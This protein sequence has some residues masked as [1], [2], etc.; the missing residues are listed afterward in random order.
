MLRDRVTSVKEKKRAAPRDAPVNYWSTPIEQLVS[1]LGSTHDG[2]TRSQAARRLQ[3]FGPNALDFS[4]P[5]SI[6]RLIIRQFT[7]PL[8]LIL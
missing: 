3:E 4:A 1:A 6:L 8:I 7:S 2:L 5:L